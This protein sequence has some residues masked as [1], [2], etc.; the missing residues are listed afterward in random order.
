MGNLA[1]RSPKSQIFM[2]VKPKLVLAHVLSEHL[3]LYRLHQTPVHE[4]QAYQCP[5]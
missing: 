5:Q 1:S 2:F 4:D 3:L